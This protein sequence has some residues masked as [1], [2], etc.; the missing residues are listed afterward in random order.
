MIQISS[1]LPPL[2]RS[3]LVNRRRSPDGDHAG[4][5]PV[6]VPSRAMRRDSEPSLAASHSSRARKKAIRW[7]SG[8]HA[9]VLR[10][11]RMIRRLPLPFAPIV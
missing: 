11:W 4:S 7:P 5:S 6:P 10:A 1:I 3:V 9:I 8:D 2:R